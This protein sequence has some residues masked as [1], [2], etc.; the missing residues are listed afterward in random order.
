MSKMKQLLITIAAVV[1]V[2]C[3][4]NSHY[5]GNYYY[6]SSIPN[7]DNRPEVIIKEDGTYLWRWNRKQRK[8]F[9]D[10]ENMNRYGIWKIEKNYLVLKDTTLTLRKYYKIRKFIICLC[11][12]KVKLQLT[13]FLPQLLSKQV[14]L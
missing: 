4:D 7:D 11:Q 13:E 2:G 8:E 5:V 12:L 1:M 9:P 10:S 6:T 3:G 14:H